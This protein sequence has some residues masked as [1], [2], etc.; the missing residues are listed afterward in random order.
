MKGRLVAALEAV[1]G[2]GRVRVTTDARIALAGA[3]TDP[4]ADSGAVLI[5]GTGAICFGRNSHGLEER[6]GGWGALIGDEGSASEIARRGLAAVARDVDGRGPRTKMREA[7]HSTEG[8]RSAV[9]M[10][11]KLFRPGAGPTDTA[12]YFPVVL[13][14]A[15]DGDEAAL[16][17]LRWAGGELALTALTVLRKLGIA[18]DPVTVA[19]VGGVF[20][21][22]DLVLAPLRARAPRRRAAGP[23]RP[24]RPH[25]RD[26]RH[27]PRPRRGSGV[28]DTLAYLTAIHE[29]DLEAVRAVG[30][31]LPQIAHAVDAIA[32]R[33]DAGGKW[34]NVGAGTS[35]RLG[36]LDA[37]ELPPTFGVAPRLVTGLIA[38]GDEALV[39]AVEGAEDDEAQ[40]AEDVK[41]A[42]VTSQDVVLGIA[43]SGA[44]P[45]VA[46]ALRWGKG[47][48]ALTVALVC[49]PQSRL[50]SIADLALVVETGPE[51]LR[52]STRMK[53][54]TAQKLVL[55]MLSTAVFA[56]RGLV[57]RGEMIAM[58]PTNVK[59]KRRA[60]DIVGRVL[61]LPPE[62]AERLLD[63]AGWE[64]P[65][66]LVSGKWGLPV[67]KAKEWIAARKRKR[68]A[69]P[70]R[71]ARVRPRE[72]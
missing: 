61:A 43:A 11:Q 2:A 28:I 3:L 65:V 18:D 68:G 52:G 21:A 22:G 57:Y 58:R 45:Y 46:G 12:A 67:E 70:R 13:D 25:P 32:A 8:T 29:A 72:S 44:T 4:V 38:G 49:A 15:R 17:I 71:G 51:V 33:L 20:V 50:A 26:R 36:V 60:I 41:L 14:A 53:A 59:L 55:N 9:E 42:G 16:E 40:G 39:N 35:G 10:V 24:A 5:A 27:P 66:A 6:A 23:A 1:Y 63:S 19:T 64:L 31:V 48:G 34:I 47:I 37:S 69:G 7:L 54:G 30:R 62:P 56:R